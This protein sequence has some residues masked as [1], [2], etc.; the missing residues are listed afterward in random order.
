VDFDGGE[1]LAVRLRPSALMRLNVDAPEYCFTRARAYQIPLTSAR[2]IDREPP[3]WAWEDRSMLLPFAYLAFAAVLRLL[4]RGR[5][6][7]FAKDVE[8]VLLRHQLSVLARQQQ[9]PRLRPADRAFI[10]ALAR[11][12]PHRRRHGLVVTPATLLRWH[13]ELVRRRWTYRQRNGGRPPTGRALGEL[14]LRLARENPGW[15]YQRIAGE[16]LKL[17]FPISPSTVRRL[18]ASAGLE[19][20]PRRQA[21][22]WP[23]F[24]R[25]QAVS[26][27]ACDFFTVETVTLRRL[28]VLFFIELGSRRVH[29]AGCTPNPSG[30]WVVQQARNLSFTNLF[31]RTRFLIHDRDSKFTAAFDEVFR[32][33][34][35]RVIHTPVQAPQANAYAERFVRTVRTECL[36]WLLIVGRRH[37]EHVLRVYTQHYNHERPHRGLALH[38]PQSLALAPPSPQVGDVQR[39]DLLGGLVHEYYRAAA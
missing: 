24:L 20:A 29:F 26:L 32:S 10:A 4:V 12:L 21:V 1:S 22:S 23:T 7:E 25:R 27:L 8:L 11:L 15:G 35:I 37:L 28:Y 34:G 38:P 18:L 17:G 19:P 33:E 3:D 5:R 39:R 2:T 13:R 6:P 16:L 31:E 14:V 9:R 30:A 36:D